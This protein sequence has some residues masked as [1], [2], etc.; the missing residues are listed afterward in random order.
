MAVI[1]LRLAQAETCDYPVPAIR[2]SE[3]GLFLPA[4]FAMT[5]EAREAIGTKYLRIVANFPFDRAVIMRF[6]WS[7]HALTCRFET[8]FKKIANGSL[9][10]TYA[11]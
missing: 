11:L 7:W 6:G 9:V 1:P 5:S 10:L 2:G 8:L 4:T 3:K